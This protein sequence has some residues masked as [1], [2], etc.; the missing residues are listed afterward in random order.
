MRIWVNTA[1]TKKYLVVFKGNAPNCEDHKSY[2]PVQK[3]TNI[4]GNKTSHNHLW[5]LQAPLLM[6]TLFQASDCHMQPR[7]EQ[8]V[9]SILV[10]TSKLAWLPAGTLQISRHLLLPRQMPYSLF[11]FLILSYHTLHGWA[12]EGGKGQEGKRRRWRAPVAWEEVR[13]SK[14]FPISFSRGCS[15][16]F[17]PSLFW[18][19]APPFLKPSASNTFQA[20]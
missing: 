10:F 17:F 5:V 6:A 3:E 15:R 4:I 2:P 19:I 9:Y 16:F 11:P 1:V 8:G 20:P 7:R 18:E 13:I 12:W 14:S